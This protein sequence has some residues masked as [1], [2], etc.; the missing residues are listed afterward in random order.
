VATTFNDGLSPASNNSTTF[1]T[2]CSFFEQALTAAGW[3]QTS[4]T[5][6]TA[7]ASLAGTSATNTAVG[8]Q[9]WRMNDALQA[10]NPVF[11]KIEFGTGAVTSGV[12]IWITIGTGSNGSGTLTGHV[13]SRN[14]YYANATSASLFP[15]FASGS[16]SR[17]SFLMC[18]TYLTPNVTFAFG[19]ERS[20]DAS[21]EDTGAGVMIQG[22]STGYSAG[23]WQYLPFVGSIRLPQVSPCCPVFGS[24]A[25][26]SLALGNQV[27]VLP[28]LPYAV[29][30]PVNP[31]FNFMA[32]W[33]LD[34]APKNALPV[35]IKGAM[36]TYI[37][38]GLPFG[39]TPAIANWTFSS[40]MMRYE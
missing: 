32:Y 21:L 7:A 30:G 19:V 31:G 11:M 28:I 12:G 2:L 34:T 4:D 22:T 40:F 5:G 33:T 17:I 10:T 25:Q 1:R 37:T 16:T 38:L 27:G 29:T 13:S 9:I 23:S 6:Q 15:C 3:V 24:G 18:L 14:L 8:Y 35:V 20:K 36:H 26:T 39:W